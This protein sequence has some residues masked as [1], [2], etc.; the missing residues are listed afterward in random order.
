[1]CGIVGFYSKAPVS[2]KALLVR[3][4]DTL[5]H[6][7]PDSA[8]L[9]WSQDDRLGLAHR[10]LAIIDLSVT[11]HQPMADH[12]GRLRIIFNGEIYNY[13]DI[14]RE[15]ESRGV[16]F[17]SQSDTEVLLEAYREWGID[18]LQH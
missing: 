18:C 2:D 1:M 6:R 10:R 17:R 3:M 4:R 13:K 5:T 12:T 11:G 15:L 7:G 16:S 14:R 9:W 8:G